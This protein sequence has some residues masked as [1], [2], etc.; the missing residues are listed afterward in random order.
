MHPLYSVEYS[1][2]YVILV[3]FIIAMYVMNRMKIVSEKGCRVIII[4]VLAFFIGL[5]GFIQSDFILYYPFYESISPITSP[6]MPALVYLRFEPGFLLYSMIMKAIV[7]NY[8]AWVFV[9]T[10]ITLIAFDYIFKK[11]SRS[12]ILSWLFFL[13]FNGLLI[14][15]NL[16]RNILA[17]IIFLLSLKYIEERKFLQFFLMWLLS[18]T[19]HASAL[20]YL[21]FYFIMN[22]KFKS[23]VIVLLFIIS[24]LCFFL[25]ISVSQIVT[26][27][28]IGYASFIPNLDQLSKYMEENDTS[29]ALTLGYME[30][31]FLYLALAYFY[32][33][34]IKD[35]KSNLLFCNAFFVYYIF[36]YIFSDVMVFVERV[37]ILLV[38]SYWIIGPNLILIQ[39]KARVWL[40]CLFMFSIMKMISITSQLPYRYE[41]VVFGFDNYNTRR[42][43]Y[44]HFEN[45]RIAAK[46]K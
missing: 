27:N 7:P 22:A 20:M 11:Y 4:A 46:K 1:I 29:A 17:I 34:L 26:D 6:R 15:F 21:P 39:K 9:N 40:C 2:P 3:L 36:F 42:A 38:F 43:E 33:R 24:N 19:F 5:R 44:T 16:Y 13:L 8:H 30:R 18:V 12:V 28:L 25:E 10:L 23:W 41:N 35:R 31:T 32:K 45:Q 14:E 37:P